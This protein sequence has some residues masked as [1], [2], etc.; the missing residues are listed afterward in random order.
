LIQ[1]CDWFVDY[2]RPY[3]GDKLMP[4]FAGIDLDVWPDESKH[5]KTI[6]FLIYDK[7]RWMRD[8]RVPAVLH[9]VQREL[10]KRGL[11]H[12]TL[13]YA[14]HHQ[15]E[16]RRELRRARALIFLCEHETQGLAYQEA[17]AA[18]APVLAWDEGELIDPFLRQFARPDLVVSSVP[19]FDGRC[20]RRFT[21]S[22][23]EESLDR[24]WSDLD[25]FDPRSYVRD[26]LST[27]EA[28]SIY[29]EAYRSLMPARSARPPKASS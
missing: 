28:A 14:T 23:F 21:L 2:Y 24:F 27:A 1:P 13:Q 3:C 17:L 29:L 20:G 15:S 16:F 4:W 7:I 5:P 12:R 25:Q 8:E 11:T 19:Y 6:D 9:R 22:S 10:T 18:G 26:C